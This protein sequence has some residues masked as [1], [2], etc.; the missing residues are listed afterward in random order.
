MSSYV[1]HKGK[2]YPKKEKVSMV[3]KSGKVCKYKGEDIQPGDP[4][5]YE[6]ADREALKELAA[7]GEE[8]FGRDF[9]TEPEFLQAVRN[10]GFENVDQYLKHIGYDEEADDKRFEELA[11][12][13]GKHELPKRV[14]E[15]NTMGGGRDRTGN[16]ENDTIGGMGDQRLRSPSEIKK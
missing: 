12:V 16:S 13:V 2:W 14:A 6:G 8:H 15:I 10:Q 5:I 4:F 1:S 9:R 7:A 3:N 11:E